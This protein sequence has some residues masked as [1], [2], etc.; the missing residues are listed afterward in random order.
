MLMREACN[1][2]YIQHGRIVDFHGLFRICRA[3]FVVDVDPS[4]IDQH[5]HASILCDL[6]RKVSDTAAV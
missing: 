3:V 6:L 4:I 1:G 5:I 2:T